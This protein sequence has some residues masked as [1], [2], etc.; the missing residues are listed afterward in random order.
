MVRRGS[1]VAF[2]D[3]IEFNDDLRWID[4]TADIAFVVM[5]LLANERGDLATR[6]LNRWLTS[7][8]DFSGLVALRLYVI[9][10]ALV[11]ALVM[12]L[13][14]HGKS[15]D[16]AAFDRYVGLTARLVAPPQTFLIL[17][18]GFSGSG[19]SVASEALAQQIGAIRI[20]SDIERKRARQSLAPGDERCLDPAVYT[21]EAIDANYARLRLLANELLDAGYPVIVDASFLRR[22]H[23]SSFIELATHLSIPVLVLH[24]QAD[25]GIL[26]ER[27]TKRATQ[28]G[29][30][31]DADENV[32][33]LQLMEVEPLTCGEAVIVTINT[34]VPVDSF[35]EQAPWLPLFN[36][37]GTSRGWLSDQGRGRGSDSAVPRERSC[38]QVEKTRKCQ[39]T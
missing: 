13:K 2:F 36:R 7:T 25:V 14:R 39:S 5:D 29:E 37:L 22:G 38:A 3:C 24:F 32:L 28:A 33:R 11:R 15:R 12:V 21:R 8:G 17:C 20:S 9:Y 6:F 18:H 27:L 4:V 10:R 23:R 34:D 26:A 30:P 16:A 31:S 1:D 19:K 35:E